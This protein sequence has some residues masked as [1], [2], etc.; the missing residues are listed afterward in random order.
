MEFQIT[1]TN[2]FTIT[3]DVIVAKMDLH[4][5]IKL[6]SP[7]V[8]K[9]EKEYKSQREDHILFLEEFEA[10]NKREKGTVSKELLK[11]QKDCIRTTGN[12]LKAIKDITSGM[13]M[14]AD[15]LNAYNKVR[16]GPGDVMVIDQNIK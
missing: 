10:R 7:I 15:G 9:I 3:S 1:H 8:Q 11:Y 2:T 12:I 4:D 16:G 14:L 5:A 13:E 6:L